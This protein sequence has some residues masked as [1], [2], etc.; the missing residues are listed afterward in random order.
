MA[1]TVIQNSENV[2]AWLQRTCNSELEF[3]GCTDVSDLTIPRGDVIA[4]R[5]RIGKGDFRVVRTRRTTADLGTVTFTFFRQIVN[6]VTDL[7]CPPNIFLMYSNCGSD[8]DPT[9]YDFLD[10]LKEI[11][12]TE[13]TQAGVVNAIQADDAT[14]VGVDVVV[15]ASTEFSSVNTIKPLL[16]TNLPITAIFAPHFYNNK[17]NL[18]ISSTHLHTTSSSK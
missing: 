16:Q 7:P 6:L 4:S 15:E 8:E 1:V 14:D 2:A 13:T 18:S 9:N 10:I 12:V 5:Q 11:N 17:S 3:L